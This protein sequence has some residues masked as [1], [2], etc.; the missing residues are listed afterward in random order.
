MAIAWMSICLAFDTNTTI[1]EFIA[2]VSTQHKQK[3]NHAKTKKRK[4]R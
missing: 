3:K 4:E 1:E 2:M